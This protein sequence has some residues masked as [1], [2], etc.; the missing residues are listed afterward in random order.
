MNRIRNPANGI[1]S[2]LNQKTYWIGGYAVI[3]FVF[4]V[5]HF[6]AETGAIPYAFVQTPFFKKFTLS[7]FF[8]VLVILVGKVIEKLINTR[9]D[10]EGSK[11]NLVR[12]TRLLTTV[13]VLILLV[14][15][16]AQN[17]VA[18]AVSF[19]LISLV[20][21]FAL[22]APISSFIGWLYLVFRKPY[23]VGDRIQIQNFKGDVIEIGYLDTVLLEFSGEY[24]K[25][26]RN[27]GRVITFPN[28]LILRSEVFNYSGPFSP[29]IWNETAV[30]IAYTSDI[31]FVEEC[32]LTAAINDFNNMYPQ[33]E[34]S[35]KPHWKPIVYFRV[36][37][38]AWLEAVISYP[39][40]PLETTPRRTRILRQ[41]LAL[42][43]A[44]PEKVKFP[45]GARR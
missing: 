15:F 32:L 23:Q 14:S 31:E 10:S 16:L 36:N 27:S 19:G 29:F 4:L 40:D 30:Q 25:N 20:L 45:E 13:F 5:L 8:I 33:F 21:G 17:L 18:A 2:L 41:A 44:K 24:L 9:S 6:L 28:S 26:D 11:Y 43:N 35:K 38:Y 1:P 22:Q 39:V 7:A 42:M 34:L 12:I 37:S 3:A